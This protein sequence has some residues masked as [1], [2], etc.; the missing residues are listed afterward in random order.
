MFEKREPNQHLY[1]VETIAG[2]I[3]RITRQ[4]VVVQ[5]QNV[6]SPDGSRIAEMT[7][8]DPETGLFRRKTAE[9]LWIYGEVVKVPG[10]LI[11]KDSPKQTTM[12]RYS[13]SPLPALLN[14]NLVIKE[15]VKD[16]DRAIAL[17][18]GLAGKSWTDGK[19]ICSFNYVE[20][21]KYIAS[22]RNYGECYSD[23]FYSGSPGY[24]TS[25]IMELLG[26][27][28]W[29]PIDPNAKI[30]DSNLA[31]QI[32]NECESRSAKQL[33]PWV[34]YYHDIARPGDKEVER[35]IRCCLEG[36]A[37]LT[38][39]EQF[40]LNFDLE[41]NKLDL[42]LNAHFRNTTSPAVDHVN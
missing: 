10:D 36:K 37:K 35:M 4:G 17:F 34:F 12:C 9:G 11:F 2:S 33:E 18:S 26:E 31:T 30:E 5:V 8:G 28:A 41:I 20:A 38:D 15:F 7:C 1:N 6:L 23:Y 29:F 3:C 32:L 24:I 42:N 13:D 16:F 25:K 22:L 27:F 40:Y 14:K 39:W 21:G 19:S